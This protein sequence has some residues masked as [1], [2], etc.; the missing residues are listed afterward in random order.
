MKELKEKINNYA[1]NLL[2]EVTGEDLDE[3]SGGV[4]CVCYGGPAA[5]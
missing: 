2:L 5:R 3:V 4:S 1:I